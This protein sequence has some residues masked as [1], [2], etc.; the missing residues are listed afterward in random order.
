MRIAFKIM[1]VISKVLKDWNVTPIKFDDKDLNEQVG[2]PADKV[3]KGAN[4]KFA[5]FKVERKF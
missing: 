5:G 3:P 2:L 4:R 1:V